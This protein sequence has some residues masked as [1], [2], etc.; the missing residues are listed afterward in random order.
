MDR[1]VAHGGDHPTNYT[2]ETFFWYFPCQDKS[3]DSPPL[4][5]WLQGGPG[6]SSMIGLFYEVGPIKITKDKRFI[7]DFNTWNSKASMLFIDNPIGAGFSHLGTKIVGSPEKEPLPTFE[8][9]NITNSCLNEEIQDNP[10][11]NDGYPTNQAAVTHD[12]IV[13]LGRFYKIF[14]EANT[15][16]YLTGESYAGKYIPSL[17]Y[18]I[19]RLNEKRGYESYPLK[20]IAI[21]DGFTDPL[22]QIKAHADQALALGLVSNRIATEMKR[23]TNISIHFMCRH[24]WKSALQARLSMY[25]L[26]N[27]CTGGINWYDV[28]KGSVKSSHPVAK[29]MESIKVSLNAPNGIFGQDVNL[30]PNIELDIMQSAAIY[31]PYVVDRIKVLL[32]QGQFD[33]RDG[34]L[35]STE[36]IENIGWKYQKQFNQAD[37]KVWESDGKVFGYVKEF[38]NLVRVEMLGAGH[39]A[40]EDQPVVSKKM[41]E[42]YLLPIK[43]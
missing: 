29:M 11:F 35:G 12:L 41:V 37:R 27:N 24:E 20:G 31:L 15:T 5:I 40:P 34:V 17:A 10:T 26:F 18:R 25:D 13:F 28:R 30:Y 23:L 42:K 33:L 36:Y 9:V 19:L 7:R 38:Q 43:K 1:N 14:P 39:Y 22:T 16:L 4:I 8:N 3:I 2:A 6:S 21:G 32:Y